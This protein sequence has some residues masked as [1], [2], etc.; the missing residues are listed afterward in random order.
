MTGSETGSTSHSDACGRP[1]GKGDCSVRGA[2]RP[3]SCIDSGTWARP[4]SMDSA[5]EAETE[6]GS[7]SI[8]MSSGS[9]IWP[10]PKPLGDMSARGHPVVG[11]KEGCG[12]SIRNGKAIVDGMMV[13]VGIASIVVPAGVAIL[14][15]GVPVTAGDMPFAVPVTGTTSATSAA[16]ASTAIGIVSRGCAVCAAREPAGMAVI[17]STRRSTSL[18]D[19][20]RNEELVDR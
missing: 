11:G 3:A 8:D 2:V 1:R 5:A 19:A 6:A 13:P 14:D 20:R 12:G 15:M 10:E 16:A 9:G 17:A 7:V 18:S 4:V